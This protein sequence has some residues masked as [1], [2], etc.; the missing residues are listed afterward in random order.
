MWTP[1]CQHAFEEVKEKLSSEPIFTKYRPRL[2]CIQDCD[3]QNQTLGAVLSPKAS[4]SEKE[5]SHVTLP[6]TST[7]VYQLGHLG[8]Q[9]GPPPPERDISRPMVPEAYREL[10]SKRIGCRDRDTPRLPLRRIKTLHIGWCAGN[11]IY[12]EP[13]QNEPRHCISAFPDSTN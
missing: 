5:F 10:Q 6:K 4:S 3:Y 2:M 9:I 7:K 11:G 1:E 8:F 13:P 12:Q